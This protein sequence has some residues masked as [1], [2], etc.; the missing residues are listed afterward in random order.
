MVG[1]NGIVVGTLS[2]NEPLWTLSYEIWFYLSAG[3]VGF[4]L[5]RR[6]PSPWALLIVA[7]SIGVFSVLSVRYLVYWWAGALA[8]LF[9]GKAGHRA[10][11][12]FGMALFI[13]G[14]GAYELAAPSRSFAGTIFLSP[15]AAESLIA[16][17]IALAILMLCDARINEGLAFAR[18]PAIYLSSISYTLYLV[19]YPLNLALSH[20][21]PRASELS[22][23]SVA[24]FC[25]RAAIVFLIANV[26][27]LAFEANTGAVRRY[28]K[29][30]LSAGG[31]PS[32]SP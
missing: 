30:R 5:A 8:V 20:F 26:F 1:L 19:H 31:M 6:T 12:V 9:V 2:L 23:H 25:T 16:V 11:G 22:W 13:V 21:F 3:A 32:P 24:M 27:Y 29:R 7:C 17:G 28:L 15:A 4:L 18:R 10:L 14:C